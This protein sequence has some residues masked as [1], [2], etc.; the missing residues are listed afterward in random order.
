MSLSGIVDLGHEKIWSTHPRLCKLSF[1]TWKILLNDSLEQNPFREFEKLIVPP[2]VKTFP[3]FLI[4]VRFIIMF[5]R[6]CH[7]SVSR[8]TL[9]HATPYYLVY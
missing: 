8:T 3:A 9:I 7:W 4:P 2:L 6:A 5:E 1:P